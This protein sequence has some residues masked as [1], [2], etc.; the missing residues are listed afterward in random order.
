MDVVEAYNV[1]EEGASDGGGRVG[2]AEHYEVSVLRGNVEGLKKASRM[3]CLSLVALAD[4]A[5]AHEVTHD[6][7]VMIHGEVEAEPL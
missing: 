1:V 3:K 4:S 6:R 2:V 7:A 5:C